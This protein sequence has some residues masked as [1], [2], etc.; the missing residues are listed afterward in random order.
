MVC[1]VIFVD[2]ERHAVVEQGFPCFV[3]LARCWLA[4]LSLWRQYS[5]LSEARFCV[6]P[7]SIMVHSLLVSGWRAFCTN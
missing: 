1:F 4:E 2:I 5:I 6:V 7:G 3:R